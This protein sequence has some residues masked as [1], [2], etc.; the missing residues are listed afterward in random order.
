MK[1]KTNYTF[2]IGCARS[3]TSILGEL[4]AS[5]PRVKY[6]FEAIKIWEFGGM[7]EYDSHRLTELHATDAVKKHVREY[8]ENQS[9][10][11]DFVVEKNPRNS[12]RIPYV[13]AIFPDAK[14][15]YIVRDGRDVACSLVPGCG[16]EKW[17]HNRPPAWHEYYT[18]YEGALRCAYGW[19]DI[20]EIS[21]RDLSLVPHI[22]IRYEDLISSP[23]RVATDIFKFMGLD[24]HSDTVEFC[25]KI[26][27]DTSFDYHAKFQDQW[28]RNNH[29]SRIGRWRENLNNDEKSAIIPLLSPLLKKLGYLVEDGDS[30][31]NH[32]LSDDD[33]GNKEL[34]FCV[35]P[36]QHARPPKL[37]IND[38]AVIFHG[39]QEYILTTTFV[40]I[41]K[42]DQNLLKKYGYLQHFINHHYLQGRSFLDLG[43]N[44]GFF[45]FLALQN[46]AVKATALDI[47]QEY[48]F[49]IMKARDILGFDN[50]KVVNR[51]VSDW[52]E[53]GDVVLAMALVHWIYSCT[54]NYGSLD[55]V[56]EK[57]ASLTNYILIIEW[58]DPS[59][60]AIEFFKH[61]QWNQSNISEPYD[62][63][64]F[65]KALSDHFSSYELIGEISD[66][67]RVFI[68][69]K[70]PHLVDNSCPLPLLYPRETVI[71]CRLLAQDIS[72]GM[73]YWSR[74]YSLDGVICK[75]ATLNLA[76]REAEFL[77]RLSGKAYF[78][79]L[80]KSEV[81]V[82]DGYSILLLEKI[83]GKSL[84][85]SIP[86]ILESRKTFYE[87]VSSVLE[88]L[89][90]LQ[91]AGILHR[92]IRDDNFLVCDN[93]PILIDFG[94]AISETTT[95]FTP[96]EL[97]VD[98]TPPDKSF[99]NVYQM[100]ILLDKI[101]SNRYA[102]F[103]LVISRMID[104]DS[105]TRT[106]DI[107]VLR[108]LFEAVYRGNAEA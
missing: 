100:G 2:V 45:C 18:K 88:I 26:S 73:P 91:S 1:N 54:A 75:Q 30:V 7:G 92:D 31:N 41:L 64:M 93:I 32:L 106:E 37:N 42:S 89:A 53:P 21:L 82:D 77:N 58:V 94:W 4:V 44:A 81:I 102:D 68:A 9:Q 96:S 24:M 57:L 104:P 50:L 25:K 33:L 80:L 72:N 105:T 28:F 71:S 6:I 17:L 107:T 20:V 48:L 98:K 55:S 103:D 39:Y 78:P 95:F 35:T 12:L 43:A 86:D 3:G 36:N 29:S 19:R 56:V 15:I 22:M 40:S 65:L 38:D 5:H 61:T 66:T 74:V 76:D 34:H 69:Y 63:L 59:D 101:N 67:R 87:F 47:D 85:E 11:A 23:L 52:N 60:P 8:F 10:G 90:E 84:V 16:G 14:F 27:D 97:G 83:E 70:T 46:G 49:M 108:N 99:S 62:Y 51:N 13:H 79:K